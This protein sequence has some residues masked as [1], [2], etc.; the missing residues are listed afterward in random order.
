MENQYKQL[1]QIERYQIEAL[2]KL[3]HSAR[4]IA[5]KLKRSNKT[6]SFELRR[7]TPYCAKEAHEKAQNLRK[8]TNKA[9]KCNDK[10]QEKFFELLQLSFSPEQISGRMKSENNP[11][12]VCPNT[13]Y[14]L[15]KTKQWRHLLARKGKAYRTKES[16]CAGVKHI[17]HRVDIEERPAFVDE[18]IQIG[19]WEAD[20]VYGQDGYFVTLVERVTKL[21][22]VRRTKTKSKKEVSNAIKEMM[23]PFQS[24]CH[25][26]TFD[27][28]GEFAGHED[29]K[30][31]LKCDTFFAKPYHSWL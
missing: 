18:K 1:T 23:M 19:H 9:F 30:K 11:Y 8:N 31:H 27:N 4:Y 16:S 22:V 10:M 5:K 29:I 2:C 12:A 17:P 14:R 26:I 6:I 13:I 7:C 21:L 28:G 15:I 3:D 20:T 24:I 25:S